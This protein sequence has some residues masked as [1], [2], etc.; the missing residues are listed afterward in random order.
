MYCM[1][2]AKI[3]SGTPSAI[4]SA[5]G[6]T[7]G[8]GGQCPPTWAALFI[9]TG[10]AVAARLV[11]IGNLDAMALAEKLAPCRGSAAGWP[12]LRFRAVPGQSLERVRVRLLAEDAASGRT[13]PP[14]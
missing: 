3:W 6:E 12:D 14:R 9:L 1:R 2:V 7:A 4:P 5:R 11:R 8:R 10:L 13:A